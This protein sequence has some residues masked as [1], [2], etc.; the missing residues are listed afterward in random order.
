M[1]VTDAV[2]NTW[3]YY[4]K[5]AK[6]Y[7]ERTKNRPFARLYSRFAA[8]VPAGGRVLDLGCGPG[9]D[10][11]VLHDKGYDVVLTDFSFE[12]LRMAT[13]SPRILADMR[14]LPFQRE[15]F[16]GVWAVASLLH[17]PREQIQDVLRDILNVL[18]PG[19]VLLSTLKS[20]QALQLPDVRH[21]EYYSPAEWQDRLQKAGFRMIWSEVTEERREVGGV[22]YEIPWIST[23]AQKGSD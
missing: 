20:D 1:E 15:S 2:A 8:H 22:V 11:Q 23:L 10:A 5:N 13:C 16:D 3:T 17:I 6:R 12:M 18:T 14:R 21:Y 4:E 19:G 7:A 9:F